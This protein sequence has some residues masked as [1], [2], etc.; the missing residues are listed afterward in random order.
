MIFTKYYDLLGH[1]YG[2]LNLLANEVGEI[3]FEK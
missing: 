1:Y 2:K 3:N